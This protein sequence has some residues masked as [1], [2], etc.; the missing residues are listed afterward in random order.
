MCLA[1][2]FYEPPVKINGEKVNIVSGRKRGRPKKY[3]GLAK[4]LR[5]PYTHTC[6]HIYLYG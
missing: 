1:G 4:D 3:I 5:P 2:E 6:V